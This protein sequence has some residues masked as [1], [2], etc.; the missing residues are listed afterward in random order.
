VVQEI[1]ELGIGEDKILREGLF[2]HDISRGKYLAMMW[3]L[4]ISV[5]SSTNFDSILP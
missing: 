2:A 3:I 5:M 1:L 4:P